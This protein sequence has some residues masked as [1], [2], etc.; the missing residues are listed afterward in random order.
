MEIEAA[1]EARQLAERAVRQ[2]GANAERSGDCL[3]KLAIRDERP[4]LGG[5]V[6]I[7]LGKRDQTQKLPWNRLGVGSPVLLTEEGVANQH[8]W[9]G[10]VCRRDRETLDL[11]LAESPEPIADRPTFRL[12]LSSDQISRQRQL[13]ALQSALRAER[14]RLAQLRDVLLVQRPVRFESPQPWQPFDV[15]LNDSQLEAVAFTLSAQ[16]V[17]I[18]HGPPGTGKTRSV[19]EAIRQAV[20]RGQKVLACAKQPGSG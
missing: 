2:T 4:A 11:A 14:G 5:R 13:A 6:G 3:V 15:G 9:R 18:V 19:V 8:G 20:A 17:A 1:A 16:D 10:V 7:T 12:D